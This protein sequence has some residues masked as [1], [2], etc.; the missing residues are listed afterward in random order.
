[1]IKEFVYTSYRFNMK[2]NLK[3]AVFVLLVLAVSCQKEKPTAKNENPSSVVLNKSTEEYLNI[4]SPNWDLPKSDPF[5]LKEIKLDGKEVEITVSYSGGCAPHSFRIIWD[6]TMI[7]SNPPI[8]NIAVLHDANGD[9]CEAYITEVLS[10]NLDSLIGS[11][12]TGEISIDGVSGWDISDSAV[13]EGNKYEFSFIESD[14]CNITVLAKEAMCG[15]GLYQSTWFA[16][17]DSI[18]AG[19]P[20][21]YYNMFL[22]P[23][24]IAENLAG[25]EP[26]PG[27]KYSIGARIDNSE[28]EFSDIAVCLAYPGP[29]IPV[30]IICITEAK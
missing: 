27:Q 9:M 6:E 23:V 15:S 25:F 30:R 16:L 17:E 21:I 5:E 10:L 22:Q 2:Y 4:T 20:G 13:Y 12:G 3:I 8:V 24:S 18:N 1:L 19:I 26:V 29:S 11:I 28:H 14:T 7:N